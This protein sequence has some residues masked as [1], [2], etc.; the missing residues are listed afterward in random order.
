MPK[1]WYSIKAAQGA[2]VAEV[3]ILSEIGYWGVTAQ[4]FIRDLREQTASASTIKLF[5]N[6]PGGSVF[7]GL[8]IANALRASGKQ[9]HVQVLG[10]AASIASV[11]AMA[12]DKI[13]MPSNTMMFV[14]DPISAVYGNAEE[15][16][17]AAD[18]LDKVRSSLVATYMARF[19]GSEQELSDLLA[20]E[21][22]LTAD[23]CLQHGF[24]DEV[25]DPVV[26]EAR[27]DLEQLPE[28][29]RKIFEAKQPA[30]R[31]PEP[32]VREPSL[33]A[34]IQ[35][36]AKEHGL[37]AL[38]PVLAVDARI[39]DAESAAKVIADAR[40]IVQFCALAGHADQA[41]GLVRAG[42]TVADARAALLDLRAESD[43]HINTAR[44]A[45]KTKAAAAGAVSPTALWAEIEANKARSYK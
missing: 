22:Y 33:A 2:D 38:L 37:E 29:V 41:S 1:N 17:A 4:Q 6:S 8:A 21:T 5:I 23:E 24:A 36:L 10:I 26:M 7:D 42:K 13:T 19:K 12:G 35:A 9:V 14:H 32:P 15:L 20:A 28:H 40:E 18:D 43:P 27:F 31:E 11:I 16:R 25:T 30:V 45:A 3:S 34:S 39:S 44:P